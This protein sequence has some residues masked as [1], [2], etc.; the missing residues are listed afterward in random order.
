MNK[1]SN[2]IKPRPRKSDVVL[3]AGGVKGFEH[4]GVW[5]AIDELDV[6]TGVVTGASV[7]S[8]AAA[9]VSNGITGDELTRAFKSGLARRFDLGLLLK[10]FTPC[11]PLSLMVGGPIDLSASMREMV[12]E[13][14]LKPN[15]NLRIVTSDYFTQEPVVFEGSDYDLARALTASCALPT[16]LRPVWHFD[17][18]RMRLLVDGALYHYNP[19][20]FSKE[21]AIVSTLKPAT[22]MASEWQ[23]PLDLY[24]H[25][26]ELYWPLAGH[27]RYVDPERHVVIDVGLPDVAGL[28]FGISEAKCQEMIENG[29]ETAFAI[30]KQAIADGRVQTN[31]A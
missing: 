29:Y 4:I 1:Q 21:P 26:R 28:N 23:V 13:Y 12:D 10:S 5:Q 25:L 18:G 2:A 3:G 17:N 8:L 11:D 16:V 20:C 22:E 24:F 9:F 27:R 15:D 19:T 31:A 30:L 7:G 6:A 14:G